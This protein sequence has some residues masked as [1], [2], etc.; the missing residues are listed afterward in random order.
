MGRETSGRLNVLPLCEVFDLLAARLKAACR[1]G[2]N[3]ISRVYVDKTMVRIVLG[4]QPGYQPVHTAIVWT[5]FFMYADLG[6]PTPDYILNLVTTQITVTS[7]FFRILDFVQ[8]AR[9]PRAVFD[10]LWDFCSSE[11][12][13][14]LYEMWHME[15]ENHGGASFSL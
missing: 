4:S 6:N 8:T 10:H 13:S 9:L 15:R 12:A 1:E 14:G 11:L 3:G 5:G 7:V 2:V